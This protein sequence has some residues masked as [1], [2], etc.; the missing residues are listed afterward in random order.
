M[1]RV[2]LHAAPSLICSTQDQFHVLGW[3][4]AALPPPPKIDIEPELES[5]YKE[6]MKHTR[7]KMFVRT[8]SQPRFIR[9]NPLA[10]T[11]K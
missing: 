1:G 4:T 6:R 7:G 11:E 9:P 2:P 10:P 3:R 5:D 8:N